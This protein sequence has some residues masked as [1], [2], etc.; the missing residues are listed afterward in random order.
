MTCERHRF[1]TRYLHDHG[2]VG[3]IT[4]VLSSSQACLS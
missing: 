1:D 2:A 3:G 4:G